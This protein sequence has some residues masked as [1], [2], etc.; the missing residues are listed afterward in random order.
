MKG[1]ITETDRT[2]LHIVHRELY[3]DNVMAPIVVLLCAMMVLVLSF[4]PITLVPTVHVLQ[5]TTSY[6]QQ[7]NTSR[8][9]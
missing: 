3:R 9:Q 4:K 7:Q 2:P 1:G 6:L 5:I 8:M